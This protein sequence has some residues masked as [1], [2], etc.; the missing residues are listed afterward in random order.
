MPNGQS[1]LYLVA[2][3]RVV[4]ACRS[5]RPALAREIA[6]IDPLEVLDIEKGRI[7]MRMLDAMEA[8]CVSAP[9]PVAISDDERRV[10]GLEASEVTLSRSASVSRP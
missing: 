1:N 2:P 10:A 5:R 4:A 9:A 7:T 8:R 3:E 6:A